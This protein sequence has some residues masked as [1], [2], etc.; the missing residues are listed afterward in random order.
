[1]INLKFT[2]DQTKEDLSMMIKNK[3]K[4]RQDNFLA[5]LEA[6]YCKPKKKVK[7]KAS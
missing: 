7:K 3:N 5:E 2:V 1:M 6:K 4:S